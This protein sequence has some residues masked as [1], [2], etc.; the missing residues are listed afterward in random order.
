M[1]AA[2]LKRSLT[3]WTGL[4]SIEHTFEP[5]MTR[6]VASR[7]EKLLGDVDPREPSAYDLRA[8]HHRVV[9]CWR[10]DGS[11]AGLPPRDLRQLPWVLFY[12]AW[13]RGRMGD[14]NPRTAE[15]EAGLF[16]PASGTGSDAAAWLG[17]ESAVAR[18]YGRWLSTGRRARAVLA[19]LHEFLRIYP[20]DL[21]TFEGWRRLLD[22]AMQ[23]GSSPSPPSLRRWRGRCSEFGLLHAGGAGAF[24]RKLLSA[25]DPPEDVLREAGLDAGLSACG[26][27]ESGI[28]ACLPH[29]ESLLKDGRL[30]D[31]QLRRLL[32]LLEESVG[33]SGEQV[34]RD[35]RLRF[36]DGSMRF[37]IATALLRSFAEHGAER[38]TRGT[39]AAVLPAAFR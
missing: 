18:E 32:T 39:P 5:Q 13:P 34:S 33:G 37:T 7:V 20:V 19:L 8:L 22:D 28:R 26:F 27:L 38:A 2:S 31:L 30:D 36:D 1:T 29:V 9:A 17:A 10:R 11:L 15:G 6:R 16:S 25:P 12:P 4:P 21:P 23:G 3:Q 24:V 14:G 35:R